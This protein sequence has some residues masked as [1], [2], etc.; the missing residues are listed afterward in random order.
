MNQIPIKYQNLLDDFPFLTLVKYG[1]NEYIGI[2]QNIDNN[3][4]SMYDYNKIKTLELKH[5]FLEL[6]NEWW[7]GTN[8]MIPINIIF[9][10]AFED[11]RPSLV[12]FSIKDFEVMHGPV[13]SLSNIIQKRVK[14]RNIQLVRKLT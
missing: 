10:S 5:E 6:G 7:W 3:L 14:R 12:T 11:Y 1:G 4:A 9:K 8:R 2:I 13:I